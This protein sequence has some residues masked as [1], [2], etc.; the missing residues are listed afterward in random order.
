MLNIDICDNHL[1]R[2]TDEKINMTK[3]ICYYICFY[4]DQ[5]YFQGDLF[6][7]QNVGEGLFNIVQLLSMGFFL[8][9]S[10]LYLAVRFI[11]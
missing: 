7:Y 8:K 9:G 6:M 5:R 2:H 11:R 4:C 1:F 10:A 3:K